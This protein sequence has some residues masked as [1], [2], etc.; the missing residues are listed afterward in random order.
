MV[1]LCL[2][3]KGF[4][5]GDYQFP[6]WWRPMP[7]TC[8]PIPENFCPVGAVLYEVNMISYFLFDQLFFR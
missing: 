4:T 7:A 8:S 1:L 6:F 2:L 5:L 3:V